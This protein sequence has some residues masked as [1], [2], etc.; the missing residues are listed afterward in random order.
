VVPLL[1]A[2]RGGLTE[3]SATISHGLRQNDSRIEDLW[4]QPDGPCKKSADNIQNMP[5]GVA[6]CLFGGR[7]T[8]AISAADAAW[9]GTLMGKYRTPRDDFVSILGSTAVSYFHQP[10]VM[11]TGNQLWRTYS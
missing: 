8:L 3:D 6:S 2:F 4:F 5:Q 10:K 1:M 11:A 9:D 7:G